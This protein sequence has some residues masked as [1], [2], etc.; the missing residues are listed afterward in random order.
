MA[1]QGYYVDAAGPVWKGTEI[2]CDPGLEKISFLF[3][4]VITAFVLTVLYSIMIVFRYGQKTHLHLASETVKLRA[5]ENRQITSMLVTIMVAFYLV[6]VPFYV[7]YFQEKD[8]DDHCSWKSC[9][10]FTLL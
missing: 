9:L 4:F 2:Y 5:K 6:W 7:Y 3:L 10:C 8:E 1:I